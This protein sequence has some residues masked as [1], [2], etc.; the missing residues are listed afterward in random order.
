MHSTNTGT[1]N[2]AHRVADLEAVLTPL[3]PALEQLHAAQ[4]AQRRLVVSGE[5]G[6]MVTI[7]TTIQDTSARIAVLEQRRQSIQA[8]LETDLGIEG[9]RAVLMAAPVPSPDR[10]RVGQVLVQISDLVR[11]IREQGRSNAALLDVAIGAA[12]RTQKVLARLSGADNTYDLTKARRK[13]AAM[14][15]R[16]NVATMQSAFQ[17]EP[18]GNVPS[19]NAQGE[20]L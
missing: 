3:V 11:D 14:R 15:A 16:A 7:N 20:A 4:V 6:A 12:S 1:G 2:V 10:D 18:G 19:A 9:L 17:G 8:A 13:Q 5:L